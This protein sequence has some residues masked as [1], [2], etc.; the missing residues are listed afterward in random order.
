M[1]A[2]TPKSGP[3]AARPDRSTEPDARDYTEDQPILDT[4]EQ[5]LD[6]RLGTGRAGSGRCFV[7]RSVEELS[8]FVAT[9]DE[10]GGKV[11]AGPP[12]PGLLAVDLAALAGV[13]EHRNG[14]PG[15]SGRHQGVDPISQLV[16]IDYG[17][18]PAALDAILEGQ[19]L[20]LPALWFSD[21]NAPIGRAVACGE[22]G[23]LVAGLEAVLPDGAVFHTPLAPRRASG[24]SP[25]VFFLGRR[26]RFGFLTAITLR[27]RERQ[28]VSWFRREDVATDLLDLARLRLLAATRDRGVALL[29]GA[30]DRASLY[31]A[32]VAGDAVEGFVPAAAPTLPP[33]NGTRGSWSTLRESFRRADDV[34]LTAVGPFDR[35]GGFMREPSVGAQSIDLDAIAARLDPRGTFAF[36][37]DAAGGV[38]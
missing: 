29:R 31:V 37:G 15:N 18:T 13:A 30:G 2:R 5:A 14:R 22:G 7:P 11:T 8:T 12:R 9:A 27:V 34:T 24:P 25:E 20:E 21:P 23:P 36:A 4:L 16:T 1:S 33:A 32:I 3:P 28:P 6:S 26:H 10:F 17:V 19:G 35:H 38:P